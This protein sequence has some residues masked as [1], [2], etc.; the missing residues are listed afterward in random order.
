MSDALFAIFVALT[1]VAAGFVKGV[2]GLGLPTVAVGV[3][4]LALSPAQAAALLVVPSLVT[5]V[6]QCAFGARL[7]PLLRRLWPM[8]LGIVVGTWGAS[9]LLAG[10]NGAASVALGSTLIA[11][12]AIGL[13]APK[14]HIPARAEPWS[15]PL[16]GVATGVVTAATGVLVIPAVPY[17][18]ALA[19]DQDELVQAMG[20]SFTVS[21]VALAG[22]LAHE[23]LFEA[24]LAGASALALLPALAGMWL[25]QRIRHRIRP[26]RFRFC[27]FAGLLAVGGHLVLRPLL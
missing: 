18:Q 19:L 26:D 10:G 23:G 20:L 12:A 25:G 5:N 21:T 17:L 14:L 11:Y 27:L 13:A 22:S 3:L 7:I 8:L 4:G 6:W 1:F 9:G 24:P 15:S 2:I 16:A